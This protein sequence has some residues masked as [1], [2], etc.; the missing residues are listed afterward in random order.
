MNGARGQ[1]IRSVRGGCAARTRI[2]RS[3]EQ[4][5]IERV[6]WIRPVGEACLP[7]GPSAKHVSFR[8]SFWAGSGRERPSRASG[9]RGSVCVTFP[10]AIIG[11]SASFFGIHQVGPVL[12][13]R[14]VRIC[15]EGV[16]YACVLGFI[17]VGA[18]LRDI[19]LLFVLAGL[20]VGP[21]LFNWRMVALSLGRLA[22]DRKVAD[23]VTA[24]HPFPV[25]IGCENQRPRL[26]S[27]V[28]VFED[29]VVPEPG[30]GNPAEGEVTRAGVI[31]PYVAPGS[32]S[33]AAYR[34]TL[35]RRG[36]YRF[37]PLQVSTRFP[38]GLLKA[39]VRLPKYGRILV[40]PRLGQL[41]PH[42]IHLLDTQRFGHQQVQHRQGPIDGDYYGLREWQP[43]DSKRWIHWRATARLGRLAVREFERQQEHDL[44]LILDLWV[45]PEAEP[46]DRA[47]VELAISFSAT[48]VEEMSRRGRSRLTVAVAGEPAG[49]WSGRATPVFGRQI[50]ERLAM[51][52]PISEDRLAALVGGMVLDVP[53]GARLLVVSTRSGNLGHLHRSAD[54]ADKLRHQRALA[55]V[56]WLDVGSPQMNHLFQW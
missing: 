21:F 24:G 18:T 15:P 40:G 43:G 8:I 46:A 37:G 51:V 49:C 39:S 52:H 10:A 41:T 5:S 32:R 31:L 38:L 3:G 29:A 47:R 9:R 50:L 56:I 11:K 13:R 34:L 26:G 25:E 14:S 48:V 19:N 30:D 42:W 22:V 16:Y 1:E 4:K 20:M 12:K 36:R 17:V 53:L 2:A 6:V 44:V 23:Y 33:Q 54:F 7:C 55:N 35:P 27:W 45:P 28:L